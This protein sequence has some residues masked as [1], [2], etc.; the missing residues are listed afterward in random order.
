MHHPE[1]LSVV[2]EFGF[3]FGRWSPK[4]DPGFVA[5]R[6]SQEL[7][8]PGVA[9]VAVDA[10]AVDAHSVLGHPVETFETFYGRLSDCV[11]LQGQDQGS[12]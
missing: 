5:G 2:C 10:A 8:Q 9:A 3:G 4:V 1:S 7:V 11:L 12:S 6:V